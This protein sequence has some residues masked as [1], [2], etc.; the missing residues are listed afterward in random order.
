MTLDWAK[1]SSRVEDV[2]ARLQQLL[3]L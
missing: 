3:G 1:A 2:T